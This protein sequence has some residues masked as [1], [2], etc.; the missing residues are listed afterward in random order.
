VDIS[1]SKTNYYFDNLIVSGDDTENV[2]YI[3]RHQPS[4]EWLNI[5]NRDFDIYSGSIT[6]YTLDG[7]KINSLL[8]S[9]GVHEP[10][11]TQFKGAENECI[12]VIESI[13]SVCSGGSC[14]T[15]YY[16]RQ[17]CSSGGGI[18][19][20]DDG[21]G[22]PNGGHKEPDSIPS[23]P[24]EPDDNWNPGT[25]G[26]T[27]SPNMPEPEPEEFS[28]G[29]NDENLDDCLKSILDT[30]H[31]HNHGIGKIIENFAYSNNT[32]N[33]NW[34]VSSAN[35]M[36]RTGE[37]QTNYDNVNNIAFTKFDSGGFPK[38]TDLSWARTIIHESAHA[39]ILSL[40]KD[41]D[42]TNS[43]RQALL[44]SNWIDAYINQGHDFIA[45]T[46][47]N[48][49]ADILQEYGEFK[50]YFPYGNDSLKNREFYEDLA[51]GGLENTNAFNSLSWTDRKRIK[52]VI[53]IELYGKDSHGNVKTQKGENADC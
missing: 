44:G 8:L 48:S 33:Y 16:M 47:I 32:S 38:A 40:A 31:D 30:V 12:F 22:L 15:T 7:K 43:E 6:Y 9:N 42:L 18:S 14:Y 19:D 28:I 35:L 10:S 37:T 45:Q 3:A 46:Y 26:G 20:P 4:Q 24:I 2:G 36:G 52:D 34:N 1:K 39:Y 41:E 13:V 27:P 5:E 29:I 50:G 49:M 51:W 23:V 11:Q 25:G 21:G 17:V 53:R